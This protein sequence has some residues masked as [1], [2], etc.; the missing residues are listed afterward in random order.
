MRSP[1]DASVNIFDSNPPV[2]SVRNIHD[3]PIAQE[4]SAQK[5][6]QLKVIC[7]NC[8]SIRS[9][10]KRAILEGLV[11]EHSPDII[12]GCE[13]H[14]DNSIESSEV[15]PSEFIVIRKDRSLG[16]GGVFLCFH[17]SLPVIEQPTLTTEAEAIW[18]KLMLSG[19]S[20]FYVCSFY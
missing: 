3:S 17:K 5:S 14:L 11:F 4:Q 10:E 9:Q 16:G 1:C 6:N 20:P 18:A 8:R 7:L 2:S 19:R 15:F 13:S 12:I